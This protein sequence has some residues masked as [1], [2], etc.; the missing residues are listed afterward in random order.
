MDK[1]NVSP[2]YRLLK[3][4]WL[5]FQASILPVSAIYLSTPPAELSVIPVARIGLFLLGAAFLV[6]WLIGQSLL[7]MYR[8]PLG[9]AVAARLVGSQAFQFVLIVLTG[10]SWTFAF[11]ASF[12]TTL[13]AVIIIVMILSG[14]KMLARPVRWL[15]V[16]F[17]LCLAFLCLL[18]LNIFLGPLFIGF[19][20]LETWQ[21]VLDIAAMALSIGQTVYAL[22]SFSIFGRPTRL[23]PLYDKAWQKWAPATVIV[24]IISAVAAVVIAGTRGIH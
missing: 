21:V 10:A 4:I 17:Y 15:K 2:V 5:L 11:Y 8:F 3:W 24:L 12:I 7:A 23:G 20:G 9:T 6:F 1:V 16:F 13:T 22:Y 14:W 18:F 19:T